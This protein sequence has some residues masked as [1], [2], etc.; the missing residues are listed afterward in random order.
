[1][2]H[3]FVFKAVTFTSRNWFCTL[4]RLNIPL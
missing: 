3:V 2:V 1:M 4:F